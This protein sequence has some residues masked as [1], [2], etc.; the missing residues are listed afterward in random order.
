MWS[1]FIGAVGAAAP[2]AA[3]PLGTFVDGDEGM[4]LVVAPDDAD[5]AVTAVGSIEPE[6]VIDC[7]L[8]VAA[9][10][11]I[12]LKVPDERE[13]SRLTPKPMPITASTIAMLNRATRER[14]RD[15]ELAA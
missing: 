5:P 13:A 2:T 9:A 3:E 1:L 4:S 14:A 8:F 15:P 12:E 10:G 11:S 7:A 6:P